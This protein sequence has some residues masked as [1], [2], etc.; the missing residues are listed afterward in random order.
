MFCSLIRKRFISFS[1]PF[2]T[3]HLRLSRKQG[4][5]MVYMNNSWRTVITTSTRC[6][7]ITFWMCIRYLCGMIICSNI[8]LTKN[9]KGKGCSGRKT[10]PPPKYR[11]ICS[12]FFFPFPSGLKKF[13]S[14]SGL[15][16]VLY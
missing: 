12:S 5:Y 3:C 1:I 9:F 7:L 13:F 2:L 15:T 16:R 6:L 10:T 4:L 8:K 11:M 14:G